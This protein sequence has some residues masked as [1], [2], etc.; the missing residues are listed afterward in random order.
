MIRQTGG[1]AVAAIST[2]SRPFSSAIIRA[3]A[4]GMMPSWAPSS[5]MTRTSLARMRSLILTV[6][7]S[8]RHLLRGR[9][10]SGLLAR[11]P[12]R[13]RARHLLR[14]GLHRHGPEVSGLAV[15]HGDATGLHLL[16]PHHEH[17]GDLLDLALAYL[18]A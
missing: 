15:P 10:S 11:R 8:M 3:C 16:V 5:S 18:V 7:W 14:Q 2:R 1:V 6:L 17:V 9:P 4:G 13:A 12:L